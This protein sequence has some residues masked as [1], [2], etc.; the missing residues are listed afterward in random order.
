MAE[1]RLPLAVSA[2]QEHQHHQHEQGYLIRASTASERACK[3]KI[4][5]QPP[6]DRRVK[7]RLASRIQQGTE[8]PEM[9]VLYQNP[10]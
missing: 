1:T 5:Q 4:H 3:L 9:R 8:S 2:N 10:Q 6:P 7:C